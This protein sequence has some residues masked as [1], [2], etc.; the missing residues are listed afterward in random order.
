MKKSGM[1]V[2][3][4]WVVAVLSGL[5]MPGLE[6]ANTYRLYSPDRKLEL[7]VTL[8][9]DVK[10]QLKYGK[11]QIVEPSEIGMSLA[12]GSQWGI[13]P[14]VIGESERTVDEKVFPV[15]GKF[16]SVRDNFR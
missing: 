9:T 7:T 11:K 14:V 16:S 15:C 4:L 8:G 3:C 1:P 2:V 6:A 5:V 13:N 10:Y 12:D